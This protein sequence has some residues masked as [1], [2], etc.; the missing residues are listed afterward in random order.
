MSQDSH[1]IVS[2][3]FTKSW[4]NSSRFI[5]FLSLF[6]MMAFLFGACLRL[7][8]QKYQGKPDIEIQ[9]SSK[10]TPEYK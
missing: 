4:V 9:S 2:K 5:F 6:S 3:D 7:Y 8:N 10:Y 1:E